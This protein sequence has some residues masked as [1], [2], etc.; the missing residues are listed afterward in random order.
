MNKR[1]LT[2]LLVIFLLGLLSYF[3]PNIQELTG[4]TAQSIEYPK[5]PATLIK[6][7]D[8]DTIH[9]L[10]NGEDQTI[11]MLG[12]NAPEKKMP[13]ANESRLFLEQFLNKT[14]YLQRDKED[15]DK[16]HRKLR[17]IFAE[18]GE[19][20]LNLELLELGYVNSYIFGE[21][22]YNEELLRAENQARSMGLGIWQKSEEKCAVQNCIILNELNASEE[23]FIILNTCSFDCNLE[24]WFAK[25]TGRNIISLENLPAQKQT[26]Y[27]S[28]GKEIW[29]DYHDSFFIFDKEGKLVIFFSY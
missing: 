3:Y 22:T 4:Q 21:Q 25:D 6:V 11:R 5:E 17:Y 29:N 8:G 7:T 19:R 15:E 9:A 28:E 14:I 16:Y 12:I 23:S 1:I 27:H 24:G 18:N 2:F 10:V 20:F 13:L 26:T